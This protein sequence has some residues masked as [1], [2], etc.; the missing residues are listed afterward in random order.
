MTLC[1]KEI[2][3]TYMIIKMSTFLEHSQLIYITYLLN[4]NQD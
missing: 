1:Y 2:A 4:E 3:H